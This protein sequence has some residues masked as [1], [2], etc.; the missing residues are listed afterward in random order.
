MPFTIHSL[1]QQPALAD[2]VAQWQ[3]KE[4]L[5]EGLYSSLSL[6]RQSL[7][8]HL[9]GDTPIPTTGVAVQ[10]GQAWGCLSLVSY[11]ADTEQGWQG[12]EP[13]WV[14]GVY[15]LP[16]F[17]RQGLARALLAHAAEEAAALEAQCLWLVTHNAEDFY[18]RLGWRALRQFI[19]DGRLV[20]LMEQSLEKPSVPR[21]D[22]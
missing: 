18:H 5:R 21:V 11:Q 13:L 8:P 3:H 22:R 16:E 2:I 6:R 15:V 1:K 12:G 20:T 4:S 10:A 14:S 19:L 7:Q 9:D 17:R